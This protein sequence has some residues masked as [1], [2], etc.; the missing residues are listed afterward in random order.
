MTCFRA[1]ASILILT[2]TSL[3][4]KWHSFLLSAAHLSIRAAPLSPLRSGRRKTDIHWMSCAR[5]GPSGIKYFIL[6]RKSAFF[7]EIQSIEKHASIAICYIDRLYGFLNP[8]YLCSSTSSN[9]I[10]PHQ[11][12]C[13][14]FSKIPVFC[15]IHFSLPP[16]TQNKRVTLS[17]I[18]ATG[19]TLIYFCFCL[20]L[21]NPQQDCC[22]IV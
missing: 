22:Y 9:G 11:A 5:K 18:Y 7:N 21:D 6:K 3:Y 8:L 1:V 14:F 17:W 13:R 15:F 20:I 16:H 10:L 12:P 2:K 19:Y 4:C